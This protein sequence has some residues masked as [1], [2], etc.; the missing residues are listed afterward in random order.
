VLID[1]FTVV[2]QIINFLV[3]V[4]LLRH[5]LW[6]KL[7]GAI[8]EREARIAGELAAADVKKKDAERQEEQ[9]CLKALE[10]EAKRDEMMARARQEAENQRA[11]L[12]E[13]ARNSVR[14]LERKWREDLDRER[15]VFFTE[16]RTR[17]AN[18]ILAVTRRALGD[19]ASSDLQQSTVQVFLEKLRSADEATLREVTGAKEPVVRSAVEL[20]EETRKKIAEI[21]KTRLGAPSQLRFEKHSTMAW[22]IELRGNGYKIGWAPESYLD[23]LEEKMKAALEGQVEAADLQAIQ[24]KIK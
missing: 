10:L 6:G 22:G 8:D 15:G 14:E 12:V 16:L 3:L 1:W 11:K 9:S 23:S 20:P 17:A 21:L 7:I 24:A 13:E 2:A 18:E 19:L 4:A 5:F